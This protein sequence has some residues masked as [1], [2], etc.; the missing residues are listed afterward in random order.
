MKKLSITT[1]LLGMFRKTLLQRCHGVF[2]PSGTTYWPVLKTFC[3]GN[4]D[5]FHLSH[6]SYYTTAL[7]L[8]LNQKQGKQKQLLNNFLASQ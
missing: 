7:F 5:I 3:N 6:H 1:T 8:I 4:K 2:L